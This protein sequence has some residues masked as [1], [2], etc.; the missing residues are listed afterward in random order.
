MLKRFLA[1]MFLFVMAVSVYAQSIPSGTGRYSA[2][3]NSPFILDAH[4]D[5]LSNPAWNNQYRNYAFADLTPLSEGEFNGHAGVTF[6][7]GKKLN[8]GMIV[9]RVS[10]NW[11]EL[12]NTAST[13]VVPFMG[14]IGYTASKDFHLGLAPYIRLGKNE[15]TDTS[16]S[17]PNTVENTSS[18]IGANLGFI[19]MIKKGWIEGSVLFRMNKFENTDTG[20]TYKNDGGIE[21]GA[22]FRAWI[23]PSK[24]SKV[25][26]VPV[27][28]FYTFSFQ[29]MTTSGG[30]TVNEP[31]ISRLNVE[32][33]VGLN[34]PVMD[35]IQVAGG[36][37]AHYLTYKSEPDAGNTTEITNLLVPHY[38]MAVET[39]IT[40][41]ITARLGFDRGVQNVSQDYP[42]SPPGYKEFNYIDQTSP[43]STFSMGAGFHFG[44]FSIDATVSESWFKHGPNFISGGDGNDLF[45]VISASYNFN[46]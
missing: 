37:R 10:D 35:D 26:V 15:A 36:I 44:R 16:S 31:K 38:N 29:N 20:T 2:L 30:V 27:L 41:W 21:L 25:A 9:N 43:S 3:G 1:V 17:N 19:Y 7:V 8:L 33:G 11:S 23:Y 24:G 32:G 14:L 12:G 40:D 39:R 6:G 18:S 28:G 4:V 45:G 5:M 34:W 42:F 13:P 46:K 22:Q